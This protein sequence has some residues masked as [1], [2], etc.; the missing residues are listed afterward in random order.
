VSDLCNAAENPESAGANESW[1]LAMKRVLRVVGAVVLIATFVGRVP[2]ATATFENLVASAVLSSSD[3]AG[4][5]TPIGQVTLQQEDGKVAV[6]VDIA[7]N[8]ALTPGFHGMHVHDVGTCTGPA[9]TSAGGHYNPATTAHGAHA[10]DLPVVLVQSD[11]SAHLVTETSSFTVAELLTAD[12]A[13]IVHGLA[14]NFANIPT[15]YFFDTNGSSAPDAGDVAGPDPATTQKTGDSGARKACGTVTTATPAFGG[16]YWMAARD[17]GVFNEGSAGFYGSDTGLNKPAV[18][19]ASTPSGQGYYIGAADGGVFN[20]GDAVFAGSAGGL[21]LNKPIVGIASEPADASAVLAD[22]TGKVVGTVTFAQHSDG[23]HVHVAASG[24][25]AGFH[26]FHIH[27]V[28]T[29]TA[30]AFTSAGP[31]Y[32]P[33]ATA[34]GAH[35]GDNPVVLAKADGTVDQSFVTTNYTTTELVTNDV[36]AVIH[37]NADNYD[38]IPTTYFFDTNGSGTPDAGDVAGPDPATTGATGDAGARKICGPVKASG[39]TTGPGY[40]LAAT[41]GGVFNYGD[42]GFFDSA[43]SIALNKPIVGIAASPTGAGYWLVA[44]D[45]GIFNYGDAGFFGSTGAI[46]LTKPIVG[47]ASTPSGNGYRLFASDGGVFSYGDASF[48]GSTGAITLNS[49]IVGAGSTESGHGYDLYAAD[50]GVF[51]FGDAAFQGSEGARRLNQPVVGG[52]RS[53]G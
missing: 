2:A 24:L 27:N 38:N 19:I 47:M 17:G 12:V 43:G 42:A 30:P 15:T 51:N 37:A 18:G 13:V 52:T 34:H 23:V 36:A 31:H 11:G 4:V 7:A 28:G 26:G 35:A 14:D 29:C 45:G 10:G 3:G 9:F 44:S 20:H 8:T 25:T 21:T 22:S 1:V 33:G 48:E 6:R 49:P 5:L 50:G 41:D 40:W 39:G 16:G 46:K 32:N 53:A